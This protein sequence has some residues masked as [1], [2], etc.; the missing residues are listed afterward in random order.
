MNIAFFSE[1]YKP[2]L[3]GV[4]NSIETLK[5]GLEDMGHKVF[6]FS[7]NYPKA[8]IEKNVFRFPSIPS[9][10][11]GYRL[12][13]PFKVKVKKMLKKHKI[14]IVHSHS[15]YQLGLV[16]MHFARKLNIPFVFTMH[17]MLGK[18]SHYVP[19]LS[20]KLSGRVTSKYV[21]WFCNRCDLV[22]A[23]TSSVKEDLKKGGVRAKIE[24]VP[25]GLD[26]NLASKADPSG[27]RELYCIPKKSKLLLFVGRLAKEKNIPFLFKVFK[28][29]SSEN[30]DLYM[31][32]VASGPLENKLRAAAP[33]NVIFAGSIGYPKILDYYSAADLFVYSSMTETQGLVLAEAMACGLP[34]VAVN[35]DG[36]RHVVKNGVTGV[37][38]KHSI[39][40]MASVVTKL[41][42][43]KNELRKLSLNSTKMAKN[44][45]S[46]K[47]FAKKIESIYNSVL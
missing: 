7:P 44:H 2:Y 19:L 22:I 6:I 25:T 12:A 42:N 14:D 41:L 1:S 32:I 36:V 9:P 29:L 11:P 47:I 39:N 3:S 45:Y 26:I 16:S 37:L 18:Y 46:Q 21:E 17:T 28:K 15:P 43:D 4:T 34:Q 31:L 13:I 27:I 35:A 23:P 24:V 30:N 5:K 33:K 40:D 8:K 20:S 10:Y 38:T